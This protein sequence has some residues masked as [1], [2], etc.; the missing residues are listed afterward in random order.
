MEITL[1]FSVLKFKIIIF[2]RKLIVNRE[3]QNILEN[4]GLL[5]KL[6]E[7]TLMKIMLD[8]VYGGTAL[9]IHLDLVVGSYLCN[10]KCNV[11]KKINMKPLFLSTVHSHMSWFPFT[12][13]MTKQICYM[14]CY[15]GR[16]AHLGGSNDDILHKIHVKRVL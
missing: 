11:A 9:M 3:K 4:Y 8:Q 1:P 2:K 14:P 5:Q 16:A 12:D 6:L 13:M 10:R 15:P 7:G